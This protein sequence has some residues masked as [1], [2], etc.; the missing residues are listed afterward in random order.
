MYVSHRGLQVLVNARSFSSHMLRG[1]PEYCRLH[2][3]PVAFPERRRDTPCCLSTSDFWNQ[4]TA[5][6]AAVQLAQEVPA[7][8]TQTPGKS[9]DDYGWLPCR[10]SIEIPIAKFTVG[11]LLRLSTNSI[12]ETACAATRDVPLRVNGVLV[13]WAE[14][15]VIEE[16]LAA[17][18]TEL[19]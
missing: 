16:R 7:K 5:M 17:R 1:K 2:G 4:H 12:V 13:A 19:A 15:E 3:T 9:L 18:L 6:D 14:F 8:T 11:D 10:L